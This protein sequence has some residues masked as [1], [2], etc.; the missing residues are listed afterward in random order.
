MKNMLLISAAENPAAGSTF[1]TSAV[2]ELDATIVEPPGRAGADGTRASKMDPD[3]TGMSVFIRR[4]PTF[5]GQLRCD[6]L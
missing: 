4:E 5:V 2:P 6:F 1:V 3:L